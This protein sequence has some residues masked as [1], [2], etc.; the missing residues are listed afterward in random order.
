MSVELIPASRSQGKEED[1]VAPSVVAVEKKVAQSNTSKACLPPV[2][3]DDYLRID[4][5]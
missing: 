5:C 2:G 1:C 3:A 4:V